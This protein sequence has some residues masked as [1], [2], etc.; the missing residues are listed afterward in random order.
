M[1]WNPTQGYETIASTFPEYKGLILKLTSKDGSFL[2]HQG[3]WQLSWTSFA[4]SV[5]AFV[6]WKN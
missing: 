1:N 4:I 2:G 5:A 3:H 6:S